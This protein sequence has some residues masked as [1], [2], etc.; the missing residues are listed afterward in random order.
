MFAK[1]ISFC[2]FCFCFRFV[3][4]HRSFHHINLQIFSRSKFSTRFSIRFSFS[5]F[6]HISFVFAFAFFVFAFIFSRLS[7]LFWVVLFLFWS[8][9]YLNHS[10]R[11][12]SQC[13]SIKEMIYSFRD[14]AWKR[15]KNNVTSMSWK[16]FRLSFILSTKI[17]M[18]ISAI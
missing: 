17:F 2:C 3:L 9:W 5:Q 4:R 7:H 11:I 14:E 15:R 18:K 1:S 10:Q 12:F 8:D 6:S 13:R 16:K